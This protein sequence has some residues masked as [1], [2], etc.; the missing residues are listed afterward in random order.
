MTNRSPAAWRD[1]RGN[2]FTSHPQYGHL[3]R[4]CIL[5]AGIEPQELQPVIRWRIT[6]YDHYYLGVYAGDYVDAER[7]LLD[8]TTELERKDAP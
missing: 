2:V 1:S 8:A 6:D 3:L 5:A 7:L 4:G